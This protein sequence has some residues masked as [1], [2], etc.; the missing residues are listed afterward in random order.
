MQFAEETLNP[1]KMHLKIPL[2]CQVTFLEKLLSA[3]IG[4]REKV[5]I[6]IITFTEQVER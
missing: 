2:D 5:A 6:S 4:H 1:T 3:V